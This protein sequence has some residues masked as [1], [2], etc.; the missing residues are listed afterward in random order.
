M[1]FFIARTYFPF[2][3]GSGKKYVSNLST[4]CLRCLCHASTQCNTTIGCQKGFCGPL[5]ITKEYWTDAGRPTLKDDDP[6][7]TN[8]ECKL[9]FSLRQFSC[10]EDDF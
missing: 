1:V 5:F 6:D 9:S 3:T 4:V 10:H 8:G 2:L 7:R